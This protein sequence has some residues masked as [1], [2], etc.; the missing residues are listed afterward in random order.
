M[1]LV[2]TVHSNPQN[3]NSGTELYTVT[4]TDADF[5]ANGLV[6]YEIDDNTVRPPALYVSQYAL[7]TE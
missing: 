1:I 4:A 3:T 7:A 6:F 5:A 2:S